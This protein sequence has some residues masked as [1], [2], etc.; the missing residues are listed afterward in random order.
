MDK[1]LFFIAAAD[2]LLT[3]L[4]LALMLTSGKFAP[5]V[6]AMD[7]FL[8]PLCGV[9]FRALEV[10][11]YNYSSSAA[12][13]KVR[14]FEVIHGQKYGEFYARANLAEQ[15]TYGWL[16]LLIGLA[17]TILLKMPV[18]LLLAVFMAGGI[19]YYVRATIGEKTKARRDSIYA[20]YPEL[21]SK[22]ALLVNA[23]MIMSEAWEKTA[24]TGTGTLYEEMRNAVVEIRNGTPEAEAYQNF[25]YRCN[26]DDVTRFI[27]TL[28]Q[29]L[30]KGNRE[31]VEYLTQFSGEAWNAK[32]QR[33][34]QKGQEAASKLLIPLALIF[35]GIMIMI[36]VPIFSGIGL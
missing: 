34:L 36:C 1:T 16:T 5:L 3:L 15:V 35:L 17:I 8:A 31:L 25:A 22:L 24:Y 4:F 9:G 12:K 23:G 26:N 7:G 20:E 27:S 21:L 11:R 30:N 18:L 14:E 29:N 6:Q 32:K 33:A 10:V 2:T 13:R 28:I 19:V